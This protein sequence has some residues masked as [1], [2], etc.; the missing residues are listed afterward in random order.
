MNC[1][2]KL[3]TIP[4]FLLF[5]LPLPPMSGV[6]AQES[7]PDFSLDDTILTRFETR[8]YDRLLDEYRRLTGDTSTVDI[9][10]VLNW[11]ASCREWAGRP[12][13]MD[14]KKEFVSLHPEN[15]APS[16]CEIMIRHKRRVTEL[17]AFEDSLMSS[18]VARTINEMDSLYI[19]HQLTV[20]DSS[21]FDLFGIPFGVNRR[22]FHMLCPDKAPR[23]RMQSSYTYLERFHIGDYRFLA[24]F[25]F[26]DSGVYYKYELQGRFLPADSLDTSVRAEAR[27]L[28][29]YLTARAGAPDDIF[30]VGYFDIKPNRLTLCATWRRG[31]IKAFVGFS[32]DEGRYYAKAR[33]VGSGTDSNAPPPFE[34]PAKS[35]GI[36]KKTGVEPR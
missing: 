28:R 27:A 31:H 11:R 3:I 29:E 2:R 30:R 10:G 17:E 32:Q 35:N 22:A 5:S 9:P 24:A 8:Q 36:P 15:P 34:S 7:H 21:E 26:N 6:T 25:H 18:Q 19:A 33:V 16:P 4:G 20:G 23:L 12:D 13:F 1:L 14:L